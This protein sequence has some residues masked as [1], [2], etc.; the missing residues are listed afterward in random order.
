MIDMRQAPLAPGAD[1]DGWHLADLDS[2]EC[3]FPV[4]RDQR[5]TRFCSEAISPDLWRPGQVNGCYCTF[6]R[7]YLAG[8]PSV[9]GEAA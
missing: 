3:R 6:H 7:A 2:H 1:P 5:G 8:C 4:A 9:T